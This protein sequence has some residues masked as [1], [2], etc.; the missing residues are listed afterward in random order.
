M[1]VHEGRGFLLRAGADAPYG[2]WLGLRQLDAA[3]AIT[4]VPWEALRH[5]ADLARLM[6]GGLALLWD[7]PLAWLQELPLEVRAGFLK[8]LGFLPGLSLHVR[9][10]DIGALLQEPLPACW[11]H[12]PRPPTGATG[13]AWRQG[14]LGWMPDGGAR[15]SLPGLGAVVP[16]GEEENPAGFLWGELVLPLGALEHLDPAD[17]AAAMAEHQGQAEQGLS[18]RIGAG[19][20]PV[21][22]PFLRR[23]TG[24]RVAFLGGREFQSAGGSWERAA[25]LVQELAGRLRDI[26]RCPIH[27]AA[28]ADLGTAAALGRRA[29][30]EGLPWRHALPLPPAPPCFTPGLGAD[31]REPSPAEAR[32]A[33]PQPLARLLD[34]PPEVPLRIPAMPSEEAV[35]AFLAGLEHFPALRWLPPPIAAP[36]PFLPDRAWAEPGSYPPLAET[37]RM[38]QPSLFDDLE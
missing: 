21:L 36:G 8:G 11:Y 38:L 18:Q 6:P 31:P 29:M 22:F 13:L 2:G 28:C 10:Q 12:G 23:R 17:L 4:A 25:A 33:Y 7:A 34:V 26:L 19:A 20:W 32:C 9:D 1:R 37:T 15:W 27:L 35:A 14:W 16:G 3:G 5:L 24:W 30:W